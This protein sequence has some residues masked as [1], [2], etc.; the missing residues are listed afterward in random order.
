MIR[1]LLLATAC[2]LAL[3]GCGGSSGGGSSSAD[4]TAFS[5]GVNRTGS[6]LET[7]ADVEG[8]AF[9]NLPTGS[10]VYRGR[11]VWV[12][13]ALTE[14]QSDRLLPDDGGTTYLRNNAVLTSTARINADFDRRRISGNFSNFVDRDSTALSGAVAITGSY[15][16]SGGEADIQANLSGDIGGAAVIGEG[17]GAFGGPDAEA[18]LLVNELRGVPNLGTISGLA[19]ATRD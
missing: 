5:Q 9:G 19:I 12:G 2:S 1:S 15:T 11:G 14:E 4:A 10:A 17:L 18:V 7:A 16:N 3:A 13:G 8:T 6:L